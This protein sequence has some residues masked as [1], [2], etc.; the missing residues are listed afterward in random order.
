MRRAW[1]GYFE[2]LVW[3]ALLAVMSFIPERVIFDVVSVLALLFL[4][5]RV[6]GW[7]SRRPKGAAGRH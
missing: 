4:A 1:H 5:W 6:Y 3:V 7:L 2:P